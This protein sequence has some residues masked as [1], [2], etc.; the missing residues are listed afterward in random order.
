MNVVC[1]AFVLLSQFVITIASLNVSL[2]KTDILI[3]IA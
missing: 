1:H 2:D 3:A